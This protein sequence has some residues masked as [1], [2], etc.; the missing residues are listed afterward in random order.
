MNYL[1]PIVLRYY[2]TLA[3]TKTPSKTKK[4]NSSNAA[5]PS[6]AATAARARSSSASR[7][8][9]PI[10][11]NSILP[12]S[13]STSTLYPQLGRQS[14]GTRC[15]G[16]KAEERMLCQHSVC[17]NCACFLCNMPPP[18]IT[19]VLACCSQ[20][21]KKSAVNVKTCS[22]CNFAMCSEC[23]AAH[24]ELFMREMSDVLGTSSLFALL[25]S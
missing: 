3:T 12:N 9:P 21:K 16:C 4:M 10:P 1:S 17:S 25:L 20:C 23:A 24:K 22:H 15:L 19:S 18:P 14:D 5:P 13:V 6:Y 8:S 2:P 7:H 11:E